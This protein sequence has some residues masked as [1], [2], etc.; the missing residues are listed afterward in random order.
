MMRGDRFVQP[1]G[2]VVVLAE[3]KLWPGILAVIP[4]VTVTIVMIVRA[5]FAVWSLMFFAV[6]A[7][8]LALARR[9]SAVLADEHGLLIRRHG[10]I[11]R[12]YGWA[13]IERMG[14]Q[15]SS[16]L[17]ANLV[18]FPRG[19]PYDV[20]GPNSPTTVGGVWRPGRRRLPDP[21][22]AL[23]MRH[24]IKTLSEH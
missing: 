3:S 8:V 19:G 13:D 4:M 12:S 7:L 6:A 23:M 2:Q 11:E 22:P 18:V 10:R 15:D 9:G 5:R 1:M 20:P 17:G 14:W 24:G 21:L 16:I